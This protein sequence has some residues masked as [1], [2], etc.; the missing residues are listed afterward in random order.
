MR[1]NLL[2]LGGTTEASALAAAVAEAGIAATISFAGRV[3]RPRAQPI[4]S[5]IG[6]FGGAAGLAAWI[7]ERRA[8]HVVDATHPFAAVMSRN[9]VAACAETGTPLIAL[10]R[11]AWRPGPGDRWTDV[12]DIAA[13]VQALAGPPRRVM[14]AIGRSNVADF[15]AEPQHFYLLR[16]VDPPIA[17]PPLPLNEVV[18]SRGPFT[19][20]GD[21]AL[22]R[23]HRIDLVV[24]KNAGG[25]GAR[26]KLDAARALG[27]PVLM[28]ARPQAPARREAASTAEVMSWLGAAHS[29]ADLGV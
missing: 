23:R 13:A 9:A 14:L 1:P 28:I 24:S 6:G 7:R 3:E 17:P 10:V 16:F 19:V 2:I 4:P 22:M 26:A 18:V 12:P 11:P 21:A 25:A 8:T 15:A 20:E 27:A 29:G 5:R